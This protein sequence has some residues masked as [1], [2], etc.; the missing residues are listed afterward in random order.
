MRGEGSRARP[1]EGDCFRVLRGCSLAL[2]ASSLYGAHALVHDDR[3]PPTSPSASVA[4]PFQGMRPSDV[5][6]RHSYNVLCNVHKVNFGGPGWFN[7]VLRIEVELATEHWAMDT[8]T[9]PLVPRYTLASLSQRL[10]AHA[11]HR[12]RSSPDRH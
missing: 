10:C 4:R 8:L 1:L 6:D 2:V 5:D 9:F 12:H 3:R 11:T 7:D